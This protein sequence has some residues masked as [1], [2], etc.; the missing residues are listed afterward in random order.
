MLK[1]ERTEVALNAYGEEFK[2]KRPT[3]S[4]QEEYG[5]KIEKCEEENKA[6][7]LLDLL[8][9]CGLPKNV[10]SEMESDHLMQVVE[11]L[12]PTKKK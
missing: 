5:K 10:S 12:M 2:L 4:E 9:K 11:A 6:E 8:A 7:M 1:F 3:V